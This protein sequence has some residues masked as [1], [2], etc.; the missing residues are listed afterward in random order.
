MNWDAWLL[1]ARA[2]RAFVLAISLAIAWVVW[3]TSKQG[4]PVSKTPVEAVVTEVFEKAYAVKLDN[5][6]QARIYRQGEHKVGDRITVILTSY[7]NGEQS[8]TL[9]AD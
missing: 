1:G 3:E 5:G 6:Q 9:P 2:G 4:F 7:D 8:V